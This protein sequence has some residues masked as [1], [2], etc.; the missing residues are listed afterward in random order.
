MGAKQQLLEEFSKME[1]EKATI[2]AELKD[3]AEELLSKKPDANSWSVAEI[4]M[5]L[6]VAEGG[7][8][9]YMNKKLEFGGHKKAKLSGAFKQRFLNLAISVPGIKY[10]APA[11]VEV[12]E[13]N[14]VS[15]T[16]AI[17]K[18]NAVRA[19][20]AKKYEALDEKLAAHELFKHPAAGK[21]STLQGVR[22]MRQHMNR[23]IKQ[24]RNAANSVS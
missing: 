23:H 6:V 21:M 7:A 16:E 4:V 22:F 13:D 19:D 2:L 8:L 11:I 9:A 18:W 17:E 1:S 3:H 12:K 15:Y 5:H 20:M 10:K 24:M 14:N